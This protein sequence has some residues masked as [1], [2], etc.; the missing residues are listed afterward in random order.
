[1]EIYDMMRVMISENIKTR[2]IYATMLM[3]FDSEV[4]KFN[5]PDEIKR[6]SRMV[7]F[8]ENIIEEFRKDKGA[9][10][11]GIQVEEKSPQEHIITPAFHH[12][13]EDEHKTEKQV[14]SADVEYQIKEEA[15]DKYFFEKHNKIDYTKVDEQL[16]EL[17]NV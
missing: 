11:A 10:L 4:N 13:H 17:F 12:S 3:K 8:Q 7:F 14:V 2:D 15:F 6:M 5:I 1:M 9:H 16:K